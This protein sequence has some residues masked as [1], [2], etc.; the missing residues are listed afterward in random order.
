MKT[1]DASQKRLF[2][3]DLK[4]HIDSHDALKTSGVIARIIHRLSD[5]VLRPQFVWL[6]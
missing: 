1:M 6:M 4:A 3:A 2:L 5:Y